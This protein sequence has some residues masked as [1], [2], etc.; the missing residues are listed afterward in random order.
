MEGE[1][2]LGTRLI[3]PDHMVKAVSLELATDTK[4]AFLKREKLNI[5][6]IVLFIL[7][8]SGANINQYPLKYLY[9]NI[10]ALNLLCNNMAKIWH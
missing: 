5:A 8:F 3:S 9:T 2:G 7:H 10:G 6:D 4:F 1:E